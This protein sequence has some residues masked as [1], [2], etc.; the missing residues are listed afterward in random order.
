MKTWIL[1]V[2]SCAFLATTGLLAQV[3]INS[4]GTAP[5]TSAMLEVKSTSKG[6]LVPRMT[7]TDRDGITN[8]QE[9]LLIYNTDE[10]KF[11]GY[12]AEPQPVQQNWS[13]ST[14][15]GQNLG[16]SFQLSASGVVIAIEVEVVSSPTTGTLYL[17]SGQGCSNQILTQSVILF[18]GKNYISLA[19]P[20]YLLAGNH[21][22]FKFTTNAYLNITGNNYSFGTMFD[23]SCN[24]SSS[25][26]LNFAVYMLATG[27]VDLSP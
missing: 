4:D 27:W 8:P 15:N 11:Q 5:H 14:G 9:G 25:Y 13:T 22:T 24:P 16:Q 3:S 6:L 12:A 20:P 7:T 17:Y 23:P 1:F 26:D 21:Y 2:F 18:M 19:T 10:K